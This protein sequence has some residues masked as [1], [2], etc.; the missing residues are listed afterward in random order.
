MSRTVVTATMQI[1]SAAREFE[2]NIT[3]MQMGNRMLDRAVNGLS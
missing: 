2:S 1:T 3:M